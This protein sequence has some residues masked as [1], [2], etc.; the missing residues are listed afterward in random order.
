[1][2][3][4]ILIVSCEIAWKSKPIGPLLAEVICKNVQNINC[5]LSKRCEVTSWVRGWLYDPAYP[6][7]NEA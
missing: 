1:M 4:K 6:G 7:L 5:W 3:I 2:A